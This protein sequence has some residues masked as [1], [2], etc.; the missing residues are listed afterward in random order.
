[1]ESFGYLEVEGRFWWPYML[2]PL[3]RIHLPALGALIF[4][5]E[6]IGVQIKALVN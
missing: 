1:M 4:N 6:V 2:L 3:L 5:P